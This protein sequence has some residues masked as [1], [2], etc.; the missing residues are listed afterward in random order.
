MVVC[1]RYEASG[2]TAWGATMDVSQRPE[3]LKSLESKVYE[4]RPSLN[5]AAL[6]LA[7][8]EG[9]VGVD[10]EQAQANGD[11][12]YA[13]VLIEIA[14]FPS[15]PQQSLSLPPSL[16]RAQT[17]VVAQFEKLRQRQ[18]EQ[19]QALLLQQT[20]LAEQQMQIA[21][22]QTAFCVKPQGPH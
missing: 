4:R 2:S 21:Q 8:Q 18:Q 15:K 22:A 14:P 5:H 20:E 9:D 3:W 19:V 10:D 6:S 17:E 13:S 1:D 12:D 11:G 16:P 7:A